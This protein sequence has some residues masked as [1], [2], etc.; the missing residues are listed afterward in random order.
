MDSI[1]NTW[2]SEEGR[3]RSKE[4]KAVIGQEVK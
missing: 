2:L 1:E 4:Q 3:K